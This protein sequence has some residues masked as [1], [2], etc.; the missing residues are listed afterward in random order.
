MQKYN[1]IY[2]IIRLIRNIS[3][4]L[5]DVD[6]SMPNSNVT[7]VSMPNSNVTDVGSM[8]YIIS[9][10]C[11]PVTQR[12][13]TLSIKFYKSLCKIRMCKVRKIID[14]RV[15]ILF[16]MS[17][18]REPCRVRVAQSLFSCSICQQLFVLLSCH[19][20]VCSSS[21]DSFWLSFRYFQTFVLK[22]CDEN[23]ERW[24]WSNP[25][26]SADISGTGWYQSSQ[27]WLRIARYMI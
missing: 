16:G 17:C 23:R 19:C 1:F 24:Y 21:I 4:R 27:I 11:C 8:D 2:L 18:Q 22:L 25:H 15:T 9:M 26:R 3:S 20:I 14:I 7:D 5:C 10:C 6:V 13:R 12:S